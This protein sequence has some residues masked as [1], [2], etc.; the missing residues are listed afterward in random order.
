MGY[1][2]I[3]TNKC[4]VALEKRKWNFILVIALKITA[5]KRVLAPKC[6]V[7]N[8]F[9]VGETEFLYDYNSTLNKVSTFSRFFLLGLFITHL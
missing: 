4:G 6:V 2:I 8:L 5:R 7:T 9:V 1:S 3:T